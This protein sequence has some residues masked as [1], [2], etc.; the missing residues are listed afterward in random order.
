MQSYDGKFFFGLTADAHVAPDVTR[1][2]DY[3]RV[4]FDDLCKAAARS[5]RPRS[6]ALRAARPRPAK[7]T[8]RAQAAEPVELA[9]SSNGSAHEEPVPAPLAAAAVAG[10]EVGQPDAVL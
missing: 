6:T 4:C 9:A 7:R 10:A 2:R 3:I 1:L 8:K 5:A